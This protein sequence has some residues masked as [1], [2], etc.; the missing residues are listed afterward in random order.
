MP[1][2]MGRLKTGV[3]AIVNVRNGKRYVG[4]ASRSF[5]GRREE[6]WNALCREGHFNRHLQAAWNK[7]GPAAFVFQ[8]LERCRPEQCLER[9]QVWLD[10]YRS[11]ERE[12]GY[13]SRPCAESNRGNIWGPEARA[14]MSAAA[15]RRLERPGER[16][17]LAEVGRRAVAD[18][19]I[20]AKISV[21]RK[22]IGHT[23]E[24]KARIS[25]ALTG[26]P[27][28]PEAIARMSAA[29]RGRT[30]S[31]EQKQRLR[32]LRKGSKASTETRAK[33]S[34]SQQTRCQ[35]PEVRKRLTEAQ[36]KRW[37]NP[38]AKLR[39]SLAQKRRWA[40]YRGEVL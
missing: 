21:S 18:P 19:L 30:I 37:T 40:K 17:R 3:Y 10:A 20:R 31:E 7:Y 36:L 11:Y 28:S 35:D 22:G 8:I 14:K 6:H 27:K 39:A 25:A 32:G 33:M 4:S 38:G 1:P 2:L 13:N 16:E 24:T 15:Q 12:H 29:Q 23:P 9:E 5:A 26:R 34:A